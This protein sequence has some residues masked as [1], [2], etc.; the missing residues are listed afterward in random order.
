M[1]AETKGIDVS[2]NIHTEIIQEK[3]GRHTV[4]FTPI[5]VG[6][7]DTNIFWNDKLVKGSPFKVSMIVFETTN[8]GG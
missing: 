2:T 6:Y 7:Y 1:R 4:S 5:D 8:S 3:D